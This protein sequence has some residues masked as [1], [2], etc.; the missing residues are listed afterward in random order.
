MYKVLIHRT[1]WSFWQPREVGSNREDC[2][3]PWGEVCGEGGLGKY[4][5]PKE[6]GLTSA[7]RSLPAQHAF[8]EDHKPRRPSVPPPGFGAWFSLRTGMKSLSHELRFTPAGSWRPEPAGSSRSLSLSPWNA[9]ENTIR[10]SSC[11]GWNL[12]W[13][14]VSCSPVFT[15]VQKQETV[16]LGEQ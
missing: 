4:D 7:P 16:G 14:R 5:F 11:T 1:F 2:P 10:T 6:V 12:V 15:L 8:L 3:V 13:L 9:G